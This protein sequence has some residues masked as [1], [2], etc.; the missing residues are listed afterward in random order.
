MVCMKASESCV[1]SSCGRAAS[2]ALAT[3]TIRGLVHF[4]FL[5]LVSQYMGTQFKLVGDNS[6]GGARI[7]IF[8]KQALVPHINSVKV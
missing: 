6:I 8:A 7:A 5:G 4:D 1:C 2:K 3:R